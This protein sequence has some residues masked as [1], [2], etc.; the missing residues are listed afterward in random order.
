VLI[1]DNWQITLH[2][3]CLDGIEDWVLDILE[4]LWWPTRAVTLCWL[5]HSA[6]Q[7]VVSIN[8]EM[9]PSNQPVTC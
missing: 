5:T 9:S 7:S 6:I 1:P 4:W 8:R 3:S 2:Y